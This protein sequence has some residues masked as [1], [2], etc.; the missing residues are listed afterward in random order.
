M[1]LQ[2]HAQGRTQHIVHT[3]VGCGHFFKIVSF[4]YPGRAY[5]MLYAMPVTKW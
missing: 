4:T 3:V 5:N 2:K 1:N